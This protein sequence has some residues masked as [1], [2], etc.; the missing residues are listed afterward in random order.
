MNRQK[1]LD[2]CFFHRYSLHRDWGEAQGNYD[3]LRF[4]TGL[5][6]SEEIVLVVTDYDAARGMLSITKAHVLGIDK[7]EIRCWSP[8]STATGLRRC[9]RY[10]RLG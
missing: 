8:K 7:V 2:T 6:P 1:R 10:T 3:E 4:F 5:R 9:S